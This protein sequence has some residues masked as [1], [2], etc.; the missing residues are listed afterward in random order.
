MLKLFG[1]KDIFAIGYRFFEEDDVDGTIQ[2]WVNNQELCLFKVGGENKAEGH[3]GSLYYILEWFCDKIEYVLGYDSYPLPVQGDTALDLLNKSNEY[4]DDDE[5]E[6]DMWHCV[7][8][9]WMQN[10][11]WFSGRDGAI[12]PD[13]S[14]WRCDKN[15]ME[16][17]WNNVFW[18]EHDIL[19]CAEYG[20]AKIEYY[21][22][23]K[24]LLAF[25]TSCLEDIKPRL[26]NL[27]PIKFYL[28][29]L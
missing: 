22:F 11:S 16:I 3:E 15:T 26:K 9:R 20:S 10:H 24:I 13:V 8:I 23:R 4:E 17:S 29:T 14:F 5:L 27:E 28:P 1:Q 12:F 21:Y 7:K 2:L 25:M 6:E 19:F 18:R